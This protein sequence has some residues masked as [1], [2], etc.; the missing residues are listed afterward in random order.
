M[1]RNKT[2][3]IRTKDQEK[4]LIKHIC[5]DTNLRP[6]LH[7]AE[8]IFIQQTFIKTTFIM[9]TYNCNMRSPLLSVLYIL[10]H[11]VF[12][13]VTCEA[14]ITNDIIYRGRQRGRKLRHR[15]DTWLKTTL[16]KSSRTRILLDSSCSES[17][18]CITYWAKHCF[19]PW[20]HTNNQPSQKW[21]QSSKSLY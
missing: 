8:I 11:A 18:L 4:R 13:L 19:E 21:P 14:G 5:K 20:L 3:I 10:I 7:L 1:K 6:Y 17:V 12:P 16:S 15:D 9:N 2:K